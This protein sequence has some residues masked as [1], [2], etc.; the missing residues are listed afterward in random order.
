[1]SEQWPGPMPPEN[2]GQ[3]Y[4]RNVGVPGHVPE[5]QPGT[6]PGDQWSQGGQRPAAASAA[7][8]PGWRARIVF[9]VS[10][11]ID[12]L[13]AIIMLPFLYSTSIADGLPDLAAL[14]SVVVLIAGIIACLVGVLAFLLVR[15]TSWVRRMIGGGIYLVAVI[16]GMTVPPVL[17]RLIT[18]YVYRMNMD[19]SLFSFVFAAF[20][21]VV[22][23]ALL[24]AW[25]IVRNRS[26]WVHLVAVGLAVVSA[27]VVAV[28]QYVITL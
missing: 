22:T 10:I 24:I 23:A 25:N 6:G 1:M 21:M 15:N 4:V 7:V 2:R 5:H 16:L 18:E 14:Y 11:L 28:T 13:P 17:S 20:S 19:Y 26:W 9:W 12:R 27:F 8:D 3:P